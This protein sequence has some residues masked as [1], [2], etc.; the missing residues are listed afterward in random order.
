M[1]RAA[2][3]ASLIITSTNSF[4]AGS[5]QLQLPDIGD[6]SQEYL[7]P[8]QEIQVGRAFMRSLRDEGFLMEDPFLQDYLSSVGQ[9][10]AVQAHYDS[11]FSFFMVRDS[12]L[13]AFAAPGGFIGVHTGLLLATRKE[14]ELAGVLAHEAAHVSQH[15]VARQFAEASRMRIPVAAAMVAAALIGTQNSQ[16]G[17][18]AMTGVMA[19][20]AQAQINFTRTHEAEADRVGVDYLIRS[21]Y[22]ADGLPDF[23]ERLYQ[24]SRAY[25]TQIPEFLRTHPVESRR[26]AETRARI[27]QVGAKRSSPDSIGY[28]LAQARAAAL[29]TKDPVALA[30]VFRKNLE[31]GSHRSRSAQLYG[32]GLCLQR[33]GRLDEAYE[34][35]ASALEVTPESLPLLLSA[36][37]IQ[38]SRDLGAESL[39]YFE[40]AERLYP[41]DYSLA[42]SFG[43]ALVRARRYRQAMALLR[44]HLGQD[45]LRSQSYPLYAEAARASGLM[46]ESHSSMAQFYELRGQY[47]L[48]IAQAELGMNAPDITPYLQS[49]LNAQIE[50]LRDEMARESG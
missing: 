8:N 10:V 38:F 7:A 22:G 5:L 6:P 45:E 16:A 34:T 13:N 3:I 50:R 48:A 15:H 37:E 20:D 2:L 30:K 46:A 36:A 9:R 35:V 12:T 18:A 39:I 24:A 19:A 21:G 31:V 17:A 4:G 11:A 27:A 43:D 47:R 26:I 49:R 28:H 44:P 40:K 14:S 32:L 23:F 42:M 33:A 41:D 25:G 1:L 29:L